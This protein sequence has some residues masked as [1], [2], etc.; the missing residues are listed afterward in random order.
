MNDA[1]IRIRDRVKDLCKRDGISIRN[2][3]ATIGIGN[4]TIGNWEKTSP[5]L[6][7]LLKIAEFFQVSVGYLIG[8]QE[9][10]FS[11]DA[12]RIAQWYDRTDRSQQHIV[13]E[14]VNM[15]QQGEQDAKG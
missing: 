6:S 3:E 14:L 7:T 8:E 5:R 4:G 13:C 11:L 15:F 1:S 2:L 12:Y 9:E 10:R